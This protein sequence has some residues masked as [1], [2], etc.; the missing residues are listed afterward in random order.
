MPG[1]KRSGMDGLRWDRPVHRGESHTEIQAQQGRPVFFAFEMAVNKTL[2]HGA[3]YRPTRSGDDLFILF[4]NNHFFDFHLFTAFKPVHMHTT[5]QIDRI[6]CDAMQ[7]WQSV[8]VHQVF[9]FFSHCIVHGSFHMSG[10]CR[11][12]GNCCCGI[13][14]IG[15]IPV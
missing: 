4:G 2:I 5:R 11:M 12:K 6:E 1:N 7:A 9:N 8:L 13:D 10:I 3:T 14:G 15:K